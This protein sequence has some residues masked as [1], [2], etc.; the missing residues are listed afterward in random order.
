ML[1]LLK[2]YAVFLVG[3]LLGFLGGVTVALLTALHLI[4]TMA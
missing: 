4:L 1:N 2:L 3:V